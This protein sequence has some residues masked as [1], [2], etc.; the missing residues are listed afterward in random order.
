M[1]KVDVTLLK[2]FLFSVCCVEFSFFMWA[3]PQVHLYWSLTHFL[4]LSKVDNI[5]RRVG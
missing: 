1:K 2:L 4:K 5:S 3:D